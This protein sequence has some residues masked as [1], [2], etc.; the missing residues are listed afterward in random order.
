MTFADVVEQR[1]ERRYKKVDD[2]ITEMLVAHGIPRVKHEEI[3]DRIAARCKSLLKTRGGTIS[4]RD[5]RIV[6][7]IVLKEPA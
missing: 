3:K 7:K 1:Q 5:I 6:L 4:W 2:R